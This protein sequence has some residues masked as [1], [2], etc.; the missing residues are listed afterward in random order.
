MVVI[1]QSAILTNVVGAHRGTAGSVLRRPR[2]A[3]FVLFMDV[4]SLC[5]TSVDVDIDSQPIDG[6]GDNLLDAVQHDSMESSSC[7]YA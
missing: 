1:F 5:T 6:T 4:A 3:P 2:R 7:T